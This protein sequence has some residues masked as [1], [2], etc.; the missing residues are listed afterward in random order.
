MRRF[1]ESLNFKFS[2]LRKEFNKKPFCLLDIGAGNHSA[3]KTCR[4]FPSCEYYG[5]DISKNY[6]NSEE[7]FKVM[8][9]FYELDLTQLNYSIIPDNYF[10]A[11]WMNHIIEHLGNGEEVIKKLLP[12]LKS[13]GFI[14]IEFPGKRSTK[15]PSMYGTL[16]FYDDKTHVRIYSAKEI[17][18]LLEKNNCTTVASGTRRYWPYILLLPVR[19]FQSLITYKRVVGSVFWDLLGFAEFVYAQKK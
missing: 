19:I 12:K 4:V 8:K 3:S 5:V 11:I 15:L 6:N 2:Y 13:G 10:D 9:D 7:D 18:E 14:L 16:N 17:K 1:I